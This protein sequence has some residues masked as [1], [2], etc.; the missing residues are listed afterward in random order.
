MI[1]FENR[2]DRQILDSLVDRL[3]WDSPE[4]KEDWKKITSLSTH[5][6]FLGNPATTQNF[7]D[8]LYRTF[9]RA[10]SKDLRSFF[11]P[12]F[13]T[14]FSVIVMTLHLIKGPREIVPTFVVFARLIA[15]YIVTAAIIIV[16]RGIFALYVAS[17]HCLADS[18][19]G[20]MKICHQWHSLRSF[21]QWVAKI[22]TLNDTANCLPL[23][24]PND[25]LAKIIRCA[26]KIVL[27]LKEDKNFGGDSNFLSAIDKDEMQSC[28]PDLVATLQENVKKIPP[29]RHIKL[30]KESDEDKWELMSVY[31][32]AFL[33]VEAL[34]KLTPLNFEGAVIRAPGSETALQPLSRVL[35][36]KD[37]F[38]LIGR[39]LDGGALAAL[40]H[41]CQALYQRV[42]ENPRFNALYLTAEY[43]VCCP[44][45]PDQFK[46][47]PS[48]GYSLYIPEKNESDSFAIR[49]ASGPNWLMLHTKGTMRV[50]IPSVRELRERFQFLY[51]NKKASQ[52]N[53]NL[54]GRANI[55]SF[56]KGSP[57]T[58]WDDHFFLAL[59]DSS[60]KKVAY[61]LSKMD[62]SHS[63]EDLVFVSRNAGNDDY[64]INSPNERENE[65][66][67]ADL[68]EESLLGTWRLVNGLL[69]QRLDSSSEEQSAAGDIYRIAHPGVTS[70]WNYIPIQ[71]A[72]APL[73]SVAVNSSASG[74]VE[75]DNGY[76]GKNVAKEGDWSSWVPKY[77]EMKAQVEKIP[78]KITR[79][80]LEGTDIV[81]YDGDQ[82]V[83]R[84][85]QGSA[86]V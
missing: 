14:G 33:K 1:S 74:W 61:Q 9:K 48:R 80:A 57:I 41:T 69:V 22:E 77:E 21:R 86:L 56:N 36:S 2:N 4:W 42:R 10:D 35:N 27:K 52:Q 47:I 18:V 3:T 67:S 38:S 82:E 58:G 59:A 45:D 6:P 30:F 55:Y 78:G 46:H 50:G 63:L 8:K 54:D 71:N 68:S 31:E 66:L 51:L 28:F 64:L 60:S 49:V 32:K 81:F 23:R 11:L 29:H 73:N 65:P 62:T 40:A 7:Q 5:I 76:W 44:R 39:K 43:D 26:A 85:S 34:R 20:M 15:F 53:P 16:A 72:A 19:V 75:G 17:M 37:L 70:P 24:S 25:K 13:L 83:S 84:K 12:V 79:V